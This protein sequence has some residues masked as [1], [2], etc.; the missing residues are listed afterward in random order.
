MTRGETRLQGV[1]AYTA[2]VE[3]KTVSSVIPLIMIRIV[4]DTNVLVAALRSRHGASHALLLRLGTG[5]FEHALTV[6]LVMEYEDVLLRAGMVRVTTSAAQAVVDY[7]CATGIAQPVHFLWRPLLPDP[8][9]D[10]VLEAAVGA[11]CKW[12]VTFNVRD[13]QAASGLGIGA[14]TPA[15]FLDL[16][17][18]PR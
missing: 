9:D 18:S 12:I 4:I 13:F 5:A 10:M 6:P 7:L 2:W 3:P 14:I 17:E 15:K 16:L 8:K 1:Q 11:G